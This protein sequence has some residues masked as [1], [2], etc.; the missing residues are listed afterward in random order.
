LIAIC[1]LETEVPCS[2]RRSS[3]WIQVSSSRSS[4]LPFCRQ[5]LH[6]VCQLLHLVQLSRFGCK[7]PIKRFSSMPAN[8]AVRR[9]RAMLRLL[10]YAPKQETAR[11][12]QAASTVHETCPRRT[13]GQN[14]Q[15]L[16]CERVPHTEITRSLKRSRRSSSL[17][18]RRKLPDTVFEQSARSLARSAL[19]RFR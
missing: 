6:L 8:S 4:I 2:R 12:Q 5:L 1:L 10:E 3:C 17:K 11:W 7:T 15:R 16:T 14:S 13:P 19:T 9:F 18:T